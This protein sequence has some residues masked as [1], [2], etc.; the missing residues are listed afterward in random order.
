[1]QAEDVELLD[2][3]GLRLRN[4]ACEVSLNNATLSGFDCFERAGLKE[5]ILALIPF[6]KG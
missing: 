2:R 1:V 5:R 3:K 4:L 6:L